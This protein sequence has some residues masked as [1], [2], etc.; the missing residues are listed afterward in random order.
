MVI[1][2]GQGFTHPQAPISKVSYLGNYEFTGVGSGLSQ[3]VLKPPIA[4]CVA[5]IADKVSESEM[6]EIIHL[7]HI[8]KSCPIMSRIF[9]EHNFLL[10]A[11]YVI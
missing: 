10:L 5:P 1:L 2:L 9:L 3:S 8:L 11:A 7:G 6:L 4:M